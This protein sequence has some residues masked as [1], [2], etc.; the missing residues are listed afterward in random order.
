VVIAAGWQAG[1]PG[2]ILSRDG[3]LY[4]WMYTPA[5][6]VWFGGDIKLYKNLIYLFMMMMMVMKMVMMM[7]MMIK[8]V[9]MKNMVTIMIC[10]EL[11]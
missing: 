2:S 7:M 6:S 11:D 10:L 3:L 9:M 1:N 5:F 4:I 8:M